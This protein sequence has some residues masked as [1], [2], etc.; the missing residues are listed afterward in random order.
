MNVQSSSQDGAQRHQRLNE[1]F[2]LVM[3][4]QKLKESEQKELEEI[5][6]FCQHM[7]YKKGNSKC[8]HC[9]GKGYIIESVDA[10]KLEKPCFC[11]RKY[12]QKKGSP[13]HIY[14]NQ[15]EYEIIE[16][17]IKYYKDNNKL[18]KMIDPETQEDIVQSDYRVVSQDDSKVEIQFRLEK[19]EGNFAE[20][21]E[22]TFI[23]R[24]IRNKEGEKIGFINAAQRM[25]DKMILA[26]AL[27][28]KEH[29]E[30][31]SQES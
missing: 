4:Q 27:I 17:S 22:K 6:K 16:N 21:E 2:T 12:Y 25:A 10:N 11:V 28:E 19:K 3:R 13:D 20:D 7:D 24:P 30:D 29:Y 8:K 18:D 5:F 31:A 9:W 14:L 23:N 1:L 26:S 15:Y